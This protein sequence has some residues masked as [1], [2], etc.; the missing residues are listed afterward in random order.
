MCVRK[1]IFLKCYLFLSHSLLL[2]FPK[3]CHFMLIELF[4][5]FKIMLT[6][7]LEVYTKNIEKGTTMDWGARNDILTE[8][9]KFN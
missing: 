2:I 8:T 5:P 3:F 4:L 1:Y 9:S 7:N 6:K